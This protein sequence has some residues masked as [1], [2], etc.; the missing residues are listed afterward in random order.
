MKGYEFKAGIVTFARQLAERDG[1]SFKVVFTGT[2]ASTDGKS[3]INLPQV[4]DKAQ[5]SPA[6]L[7]RYT[8]YVVHEYGH[9][10]YTKFWLSY[11]LPSGKYMHS[12]WNAVEDG[13][14]EDRLVQSIPNGKKLLGDL[15]SGIYQESEGIDWTQPDAWPFALALS[16]RT[17]VHIRPPVPSYVAEIFN[18]ELAQPRKST[19]DCI[20]CAVRIYNRL[21]ALQSEQEQQEEQ[22]QQQDQPDQG[23]Q[24]DQEQGEPLEDV[25]PICV[26]PDLFAP[27]NE[28]ASEREQRK[29]HMSE[30]GQGSEEYSLAPRQTVSGMIRL[31]EPTPPKAKLKN[32]FRKLFDRSAHEA[33]D[34]GRKSGQV[35]PG[36]LHR[37]Q[38]DDGLFR[39]R[40][41]REGVETA[42]SILVDRSGSTDSGAGNRNLTLL[43]EELSACETIVA[44]LEH[45]KVS[46]RVDAFDTEVNQ[47]AGWSDGVSTLR[48]NLRR[49]GS[50]GSTRDVLALNGAASEL[51]SRPEQRKV[52]LILTDGDGDNGPE[53]TRLATARIESLGVTVIGVGIGVDVS[54]SYTQYVNV[55]SVEELAVASLDK[56]KLCA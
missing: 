17:H 9:I 31:P 10:A 19:S 18:E 12:L 22:E 20:E 39:R 52:I 37:H 40:V 30:L 13:Y 55:Q 25:D 27:K 4:N 46:W 42:V 50:G 28:K 6:L 26:E 53:H 38:F 3:V 8:A 32:E 45:A 21:N 2:G 14:I 1:Q 29:V 49:T 56:I 16:A 48:A 35:N 51:L 7:R 54:K 24:G 41:E 11:R 15:V 33:W 43:Q 44:A 5:V 36:A 23:Q 47:I 34:S